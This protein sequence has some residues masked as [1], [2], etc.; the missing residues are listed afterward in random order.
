[1][2][3]VSKVREEHL[4]GNYK[5]EID[6]SVFE[7]AFA[8]VTDGINEMLTYHTTAKTE[9]LGCIS[10]IVGGDFNATIRQYP[11]EEHYI[12]DAVEGLRESITEIAN[13]VEKVAEWV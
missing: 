6:S 9:I 7:G 5:A 13:S 1:M 11:G 8:N 2:Q 4:E 12:N 3:S 10:E